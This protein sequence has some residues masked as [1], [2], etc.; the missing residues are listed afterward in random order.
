MKKIYDLAGIGIGPANLGLAALLHP[1]KNITSLFFDKK[2]TFQW[3]NGVYSR[4]SDLQVHYLKDLVTLID[5]TN[6][7]SFLSYLSK[8]KRLYQFLHQN[9]STVSRKEYE[10]Y[11]QWVSSNIN[12]LIF[13]YDVKNIL[14]EDGLFKI[15]S[16]STDKVFYAKHLTLGIGK[17]PYVPKVAKKCLSSTV[18]H[19]LDFLPDP[20]KYRNKSICIVGGGQSAA[21]IIYELINSEVLP[22]RIYWVNKKYS[23]A[24][25]EDAC[26]SNEYYSPSFC[27]HFYEKSSLAK[28]HILKIQHVTNNGISQNLLDDIYR[29]I[30]ELKFLENSDFE[31]IFLPSHS[32]QDIDKEN[33]FYNIELHNEIDKKKSCINTDYAIFAT[34][35]KDEIPEFLLN[36]I[37]SFNVAKESTYLV[38][39]DFSLSLAKNFKN[40]IYIQNGA[41]NWFGL[42]DTNLGIFTWR[43]AVIINSIV[44]YDFYDT[45]ACTSLLLP[46]IDS[47]NGVSKE[48]P[49]KHIIN[50][51]QAAGRM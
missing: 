32:F 41:S 1:L 19:S 33:Y 46:S 22:K 12:N 44:G 6:P 49:L 43:N 17:K 8:N 4:N 29:K 45:N 10:K 26:F 9:K 13:N 11:Y 5:P 34:G 40:K 25:L 3:H 7:Y 2:E 30:Y 20:N 36:F 18:M 16:D 27:K 39:R 35:L 50:F 31:L 38:N 48:D 21:E 42:G 23:Y 28:S 14:Y 24:P 37:P 51:K 15:L 47:N